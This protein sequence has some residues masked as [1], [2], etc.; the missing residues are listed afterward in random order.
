MLCADLKSSPGLTPQRAD[1]IRIVTND[2]DRV[3][4]HAMKTFICLIG[5]VLIAGCSM[6]PRRDHRTLEI[7][8]I[9][10]ESPE[11]SLTAVEV[12]EDLEQLRFALRNAYS[13][14]R[15]LP[16]NEFQQ[17][18]GEIDKIEGAQTAMELCRKIDAAF[19]SVSDNHLRG[20]FNNRNCFV[21]RAH[22]GQVGVNYLS[23]KEAPWD[24]RLAKR[25]DRHALMISVRTF[26]QSTDP[27]WKGFIK[28]VQTSLPHAQLVII[29]LRGNGGGDDTIGQA[30]ADLLSGQLLKTPYSSQWVSR[31]P[32]SSQV[33]INSFEYWRRVDQAAGRSA[34]QH[35][36]DLIKEYS[37]IRDD[38][39]A[40]RTPLEKWN[41]ADETRKSYDPS[42]G[43]RKPIYL[44]MDKA[45][46]SS[47]ESTIDFFEFNPHAKKVGENTAGYVH[48]GNN[49]RVFLK[50]SGIAAQ[51][52]TTYN[53]YFD[54]RF[55]EKIGITPD[56][57]VPANGDALDAAWTDFLKQTLAL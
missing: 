5:T 45:C 23:G 48:F 51:M 9:L 19:D 7:P 8:A 21:T 20:K 10:N 54:G 30:L 37:L 25:S 50:N 2:A 47:C 56:I 16:G 3:I 22:K 53:K 14:R 6:F 39:A 55:I 49:G 38:A 57:K 17:L 13:G 42:Q 40:G 41:M 11:K 34:P 44:L 35:L 52:A 18:L 43:L 28:E 12:E 31:T 36:V 1:D 24:V 32:E 33:F 27:V 26:P 4:C 29:D 46:A 15:F